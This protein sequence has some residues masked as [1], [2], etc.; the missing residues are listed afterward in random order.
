MTQVRVLLVDDSREFLDSASGFLAQD[1][2]VLVVGR[3]RDGQEGLRL[4]KEVAPDLVLM[5]LA[6]PVMDGLT[7]T[8]AV[9]AWPTPPRI[10]ILTLHDDPEYRRRADD[11]GADG[12]ICKADFSEAV[13]AVIDALFT[14]PTGL[15]AS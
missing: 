4:A 13:P 3:A 5:D 10:V 6:M 15:S 7:A 12:F 8:R 9:K 1:P 14:G 11:A 2:R